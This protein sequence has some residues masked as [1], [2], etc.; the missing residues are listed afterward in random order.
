LK[1]QLSQI[2]CLA[3]ER[4]LPFL[5]VGGHAVIFHGV[6]RFTRDIDIMTSDEWRDGWRTLIESL[7]YQK[8]HSIDAFEQFEPDP[9]Q[10]TA[11]SRV[12]IDL[13]FVDKPTW[14]KLYPAAAEI[15]LSPGVHAKI[16]CVL[17]LIAMKL[18]ASR[19]PHRRVGATDLSDVIELIAA[20][21]IDIDTADF[22]EIAARYASANDMK[23]IRKSSTRSE[24]E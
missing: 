13:M 11:A 10:P 17:H 9:D 18:N 22:R 12:G 19:S 5:Y 4:N 16:P 7:G 24:T 21:G 8:F 2:A 6:P 3:T 1:N 20:Q 14:E 23:A 15:E